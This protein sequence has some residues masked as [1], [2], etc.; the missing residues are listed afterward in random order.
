MFKGQS[1]D[2]SAVLI[3]YTLSGD[4][5]VTGTV[6]TL[7]FNLLATN[8]GQSG[9]MWQDGDFDYSMAVDTLD[10]NLLAVNFG[11]SMPADSVGALVPEPAGALLLVGAAMLGARRRR[12]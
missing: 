11:Q 12:R 1:V 4:A 2:G 9:K 8:F 3:R 5:D 10:F 6:D 7:D